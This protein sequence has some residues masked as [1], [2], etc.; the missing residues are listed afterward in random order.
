MQA[1]SD[2]SSVIPFHKKTAITGIIAQVAGDQDRAAGKHRIQRRTCTRRWPL[3]RLA[4][5]AG[6]GL[7]RPRGGSHPR[8]LAV[9]VSLC[10]ACETQTVHYRDTWSTR[11]ACICRGGQRRCRCTD[12]T[13]TNML[14]FARQRRA[15]PC[16]LRL[17]G[18]HHRGSLSGAPSEPG[19][20]G[21][22]GQIPCIIRWLEGRE[23]VPR[24]RMPRQSRG[25]HQAPGLTPRQRRAICAPCFC[26][27]CFR[28]RSKQAL[29]P[30]ETTKFRR[31]SKSLSS[32]HGLR[33]V[34]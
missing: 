32:S 13:A 3:R 16:V 18:Q 9:G 6:S 19:V 26:K 30:A 7:R 17:G 34:V 24:V 21:D 29:D 2:P 15:D 5:R 1:R 27:S 10:P 4:R 23:C 33:D 22:I 8:R 28:A 25:A 11:Q 20:D 14:N 12:V 31:R